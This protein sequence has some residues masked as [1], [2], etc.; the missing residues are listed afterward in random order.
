[1]SYEHDLGPEPDS[2]VENDL[3]LGLLRNLIR[4][5]RAPDGCPWDRKQRLENL[6]AYLL[7]EAHEAAGALDEAVA[8]KGWDELREELGDL[9]FQV[10][11]ISEL[12]HEGG[13]FTLPEVIEGIHAKM[14]D[15][16]PHVF[17]GADR[18]ADAEAV[19]RGWEARKAAQA[20]EKG[21]DRSLL[22]GVPRS[23]PAL[24]VSLRLTQKAAGVGF[25]W[26]EISGALAKV[27]EELAELEEA[28]L[29][30]EDKRTAHV[31]EEMGDLLFAA[32]NVARKAGIDPEAALAA[33][34]TKFR[35]RFAG[36]EGDLRDQGSSVVEADLERMDAA[37]ERV[38]AAEE[39]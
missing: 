35:R 3:G 32:A 33:A 15:R 31:G 29:E 2:N 22:A 30:P 9:L 8:G 36:V 23:A 25:D 12:A 24:V 21:S 10:V 16:H 37:W 20:A 27:H 18:L 13:R 1:M 39:R 26:P 7:E 14:V 34:N 28:L 5:L 4:R 11:F 17:G 38:K 19:L 6:R